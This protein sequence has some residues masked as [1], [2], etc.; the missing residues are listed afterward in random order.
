[1][2]CGSCLRDNALA[3]SLMDT[4]H[5]VLLIPTYTPTRTD[6]QNVSRGRLFLGGINIYLQQHFQIFRKTP[7]FFDRLL[8]SRPLL[9]L[10]TR[11]GISVDPADLGKLTVAML[12][13]INGPLRKE[14]RRLARFLS[15]EVSPEIITIP[16]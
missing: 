4:G 7:K 16:N 10:V 8:D 6:E 12:E 5:D 1:M 13:G 14:I 9:K 15:E 2:Y 3:K 11:M